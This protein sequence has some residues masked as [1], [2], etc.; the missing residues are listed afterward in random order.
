MKWI[1][2]R[3]VEF[4]FPR[5]LTLPTRKRASSPLVLQEESLSAT[6]PRSSSLSITT[7]FSHK[8]CSLSPAP[9][10][11]RTEKQLRR[12]PAFPPCRVLLPRVRTQ[13]PNLCQTSK[14]W[15]LDLGWVSRGQHRSIFWISST[16]FPSKEN[17]PPCQQEGACGRWSCSQT[18]KQIVRSHGIITQM[19]DIVNYKDYRV[20]I[21][22]YFNRRLHHR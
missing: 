7:L 2:V 4:F 6:L 1:M 20:N 18:A 11:A 12:D 17:A 19:S 9:L 22:H 8:L 21:F 10:L 13:Q 14:K 15:D 3:R 16:T 5:F